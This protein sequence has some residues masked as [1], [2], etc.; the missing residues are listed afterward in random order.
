[1][2]DIIDEKCEDVEVWLRKLDKSRNKNFGIVLYNGIKS[3]A[4]K[5][6]MNDFSNI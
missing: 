5:S 2:Q 1:M 3:Y 4:E 6:Y